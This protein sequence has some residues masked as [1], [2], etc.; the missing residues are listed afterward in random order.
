LVK[1]LSRVKASLKITKAGLLYTLLS[2][3]IGIAAVNTGNNL[4][5]IMISLLLSFMWLSGVFGRANLLGLESEVIPPKEI[6]AKGKAF[7]FLRIR[8]K[9]S[10][11]WLIKMPSFLLRLSVS[12]RDSAGVE[13]KIFSKIGLLEREKEI[14]IDAVFEKRGRYQVSTVEI[15]SLFPIGFFV[16]SIKYELKREFLVF[17]EPKKCQ[18]LSEFERKVLK[19]EN[20]GFQDLGTAQFEGLSDYTAGVPKKF[21]AWKSLAKWE[22]LRRKIFAEELTSPK[23]F[24]V[25]KLPASSLEDKLSCAVYLILE[26]TKR[27]SP[28]GMKLG[29][30]IFPVGTGEAHKLKLLKALALYEE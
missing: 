3:F 6:Y 12:I 28:V 10:G 25:L 11:L 30:E 13:R 7:F 5:F 4:L 29:K 1:T 15:S 24:D 8:K 26:V 2:I 23:I 22:E 21:I 17:P 20:R 27:G 14:L 9:R 19:G 18:S 16:R